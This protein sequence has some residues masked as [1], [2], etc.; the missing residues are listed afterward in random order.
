MSRFG[1]LRFQQKANKLKLLK[2]PKQFVAKHLGKPATNEEES[3]W[4]YSSAAEI[5]PFSE[6]CYVEF[7]DNGLVESWYVRSE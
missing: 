4:R 5:I 2:K 7:D 3:L 6:A 1:S